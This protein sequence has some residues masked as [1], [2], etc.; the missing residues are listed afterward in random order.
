[1]SDA[2]RDDMPAALYGAE[3]T[4]ALS[5]RRSNVSPSR[6][7]KTARSVIRPPIKQEPRELP[8]MRYCDSDSQGDCNLRPRLCRTCLQLAG[9]GR[10]GAEPPSGPFYQR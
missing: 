1:M 5:A 7:G 10:G 3:N 8:L 2:R 4:T 9:G 6:G